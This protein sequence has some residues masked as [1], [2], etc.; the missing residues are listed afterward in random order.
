VEI[1]ENQARF[2]A[3]ARQRAEEAFGLERMVERYLDVLLG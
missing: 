1:L 3:A 2:R